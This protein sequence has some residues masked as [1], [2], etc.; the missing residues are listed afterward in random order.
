MKCVGSLGSTMVSVYIV[1]HPGNAMKLRGDG[2]RGVSEW[3]KERER[4]ME[5]TAEIISG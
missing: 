1:E 5:P 4:K 3:E 2:V